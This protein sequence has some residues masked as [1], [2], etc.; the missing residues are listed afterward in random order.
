MTTAHE[1]SRPYAIGVMIN[2]NQLIG[3]IIDLDGER[4]P[5]DG[6]T[7]QPGVMIRA[8]GDTTPETIVRNLAALRAEL[9]V[10][11]SDLPGPV[12]GLGVVVG[13]HV[14]GDV[15][16]VHFSPQLGWKGVP[17]SRLL[18]E[19]IGAEAVNVENDAKTPESWA[20]S[21]SNPAATH[22]SAD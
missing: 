15:G 6:G 12:V 2:P 17:L 18:V 3:V 8:L 10:V 22:A 11:A 14:D 20:I 5:F 7:D 16:M 9:L 21:C 19:E 1:D 13:G 4:V